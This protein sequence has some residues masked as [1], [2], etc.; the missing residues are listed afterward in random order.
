MKNIPVATPPEIRRILIVE[1]EKFLAERYKINL[2]NSEERK[3]E[4]TLAFCVAAA[5]DALANT[6]IRYD[7]MILDAM[8]PITVDDFN[9]VTRAE[10]EL[11]ELRRIIR[12]EET[13]RR[14]DE[15]KRREI[16]DAYT[17]RPE[18]LERIS[19]LRRGEA[20]LDM[21]YTAKRDK[22]FAQW[23]PVVL[24]TAFGDEEIKCRIGRALDT[25]PHRYLVKPISNER[26]A[27]A[28]LELLDIKPR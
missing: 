18:I 14:E 19:R 7:V 3:M 12:M 15:D 16:E 10:R 17:K 6:A 13:V 20:A 4:V 25:H 22:T 9:E 28:I 23:P 8:L 26:L 5:Q 2:L 24:I 27:D 11:A 21:I 1:D